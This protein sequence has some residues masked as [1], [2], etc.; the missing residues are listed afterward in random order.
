VK[1]VFYILAAVLGLLGLIF[2][3]GAQGQWLRIVVGIVL[4]GGAG[5]LVYLSQIQP[6]QTTIRQQIDLSGDVNLEAIRCKSCGAALSKKSISV[7]AGA[8][9]VN[10]EYCGAAYQLEEEVKW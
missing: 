1:I 4:L 10:C 3:A 6:Q 8:V 2:I 5:G 9:F 7:N